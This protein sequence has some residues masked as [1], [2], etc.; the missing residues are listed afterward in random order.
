MN[1]VIGV[2]GFTIL[3]LVFEWEVRRIIKEWHEENAVHHWGG[4]IE[5]L[6]VEIDELKERV[7]KLE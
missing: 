6:E 7:G 5:D 4:D 2:I 1:F 3:I